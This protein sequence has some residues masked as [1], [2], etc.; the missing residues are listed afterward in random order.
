MNYLKTFFQQHRIAIPVV[1]FLVFSSLLLSAYNILPFARWAKHIA[2]QMTVRV[3]AVPLTATNKS[4]QIL[5]TGTVESPKSAPVHAEFSGL[6]SEVYVTEG[7]PVKTDQPLVKILRSAGPSSGRERINT[8]PE[9]QAQTITVDPMAQTTYDNALKEY[10]R[11]QKLYEQN[12]I[13]KRQLENAANRLQ[14]AEDNLTAVQTATPV[15]ASAN[16]APVATNATIISAPNPGTVVGLAAAPGK[17]V[18]L[19]QPLMILD[20]GQVQ[21]IIHIEQKDL[22]FLHPGTPATIEIANQSIPGQVANIFP[23]VG[24]NN[25][26]SFR[27]YINIPN[28]IGGLLK[29]GMSANVHIDTGKSAAVQTV[30]AA[31]VLQDEQGVH[32]LYL[33]DNGKA[34]RKEVSIGDTIA[35]AIEITSPLPEGS[36]IITSNINDLHDG[37]NILVSQ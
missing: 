9:P 25:L 16:S 5:R 8:V 4:V 24:E 31:A 20:V 23:E 13:A 1:A 26:P 33:A 10:N 37:D 29:A 36:L 14:A 32:Y 6:I 19:G 12:A 27:T 21:V 15:Q 2:P 7:Q 3:T 11:F 30:P 34:I 18:S 22:Y 35:N 17:T 28:N